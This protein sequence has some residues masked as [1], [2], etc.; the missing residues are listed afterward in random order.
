M[1]YKQPRCN[2]VDSLI[3]LLPCTKVQQIRM[4]KQYEGTAIKYHTTVQRYC[5]QKYG[6]MKVQSRD[7]ESDHYTDRSW[8]SL[9]THTVRLKINAIESLGPLL[10][11]EFSTSKDVG[12]VYSI[13]LFTRNVMSYFANAEILVYMVLK[14][15]QNP[16]RLFQHCFWIITGNLI[17]QC[18]IIYAD[19][20]ISPI[21]HHC[22]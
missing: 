11:S 16:Q 4:L 20:T 22:H 8:R 1:A 17:L 19:M 15:T 13:L 10:L 2:L 12:I 21:R 9:T 6:G 14:W 3:S 7:S 18:Y 5:G